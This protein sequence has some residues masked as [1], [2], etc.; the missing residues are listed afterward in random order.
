LPGQQIRINRDDDA[1]EGDLGIRRFPTESVT[2]E[3]LPAGEGSSGESGTGSGTGSGSSRREEIEMQERASVEEHEQEAEYTT[4]RGEDRGRTDSE[5]G[6]RTPPLAEYREGHHLVIERRRG[7]ENEVEVEVIRNAFDDEPAESSTFT[8]PHRLKS[9]ELDKIKAHLP[10]SVE[11]AVS[12][13]ENHGKDAIDALGLGL[14]TSRPRTPSP[15]RRSDREA[16]SRSPSPSPPPSP[17]P[18]RASRPPV[19]KLPGAKP[20][21]GL[22]NFFRRDSNPSPGMIEEGR[23]AP[24]P[25]LLLPPSPGRPRPIVAEPEPI[26]SNDRSLQLSRTLSVPRNTSIRFAA[27]TSESS[28]TA[29]SVGN[30]GNTA[31]GFKRNPGLAMYRTSSVQSTGS[32][33]GESG[34]SVS[35][36][37]PEI[38]R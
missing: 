20:F 32:A 28:D 11:H 8:H 31:P 7:S 37:E 13:V 21:K 16:R 14:M 19:I 18:E 6:R 4:A 15:D 25:S 29:P 2:G 30:Y 17:S 5:A 36:R 24:D 1:E 38:R 33:K 35:F 27:E 23:V 12:Q 9:K 22:R 26:S 34:P 10:V 3:K